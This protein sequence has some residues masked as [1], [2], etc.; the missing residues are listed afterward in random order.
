MGYGWSREDILAKMGV[1]WWVLTNLFDCV[2]FSCL[3]L[4]FGVPHL[5]LINK[6]AFKKK[7]Q[8]NRELCVVLMYTCAKK[9]YL[10]LLNYRLTR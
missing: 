2:S 1:S 10:Y 5:P 6:I 3:A 4:Y 7:N 9:V 8:G